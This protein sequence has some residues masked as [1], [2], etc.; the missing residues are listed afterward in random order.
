MIRSITTLAA[1]TA[2][3]GAIGIA[4]AQTSPTTS[5]PAPTAPARKMKKP[6]ASTHG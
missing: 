3:A 5:D 1:A 4:Y 2:L 6:G